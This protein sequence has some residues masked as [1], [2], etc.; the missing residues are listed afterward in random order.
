MFLHLSVSQ[1]VYKGV[2][3]GRGHAWQR[4]CVCVAGC[5]WQG[6]GGRGGGV[7]GRGHAWQGVN[8]EGGVHGEEAATEAG[9][10]HPSGMHSCY[11]C[12]YLTAFSLNPS[13]MSFTG[14][15]A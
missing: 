10:M 1:S 8:G 13:A 2:V 7:G 6:V 5:T 3:R 12:E 9:D 11:R 4:V 14:P 15:Y